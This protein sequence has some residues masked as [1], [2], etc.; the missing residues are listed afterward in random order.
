[1]SQI[2]QDLRDMITIPHFKFTDIKTMKKTERLSVSVE[3]KL[4]DKTIIL[5]AAGRTIAE[6]ATSL[7]EQYA[8]YHPNEAM[9]EYRNDKLYS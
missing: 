2:N 9:N 7:N 1:M 6:V 3:V 8:P 5:H 4:R